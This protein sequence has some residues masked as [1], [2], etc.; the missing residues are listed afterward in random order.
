[1]LVMHYLERRY[2]DGLKIILLYKLWEK[3]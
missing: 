2:I 1:M 3:V